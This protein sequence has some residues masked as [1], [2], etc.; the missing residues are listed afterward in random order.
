MDALSHHRQPAHTLTHTLRAAGVWG[1]WILYSHRG[2]VWLSAS[3]LP[4]EERRGERK[5]KGKE[6]IYLK[7]KNLKKKNLND[8]FVHPSRQHLSVAIPLWPLWASKPQSLPHVTS[9][10]MARWVR[11]CIPYTWEYG[12]QSGN[13]LGEAFPF[14]IPQYPSAQ[15]QVQKGTVM[16]GDDE[17]ECCLSDLKAAIDFSRGAGSST[18]GW[19]HL[20]FTPFRCCNRIRQFL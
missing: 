5:K 7:K 14:S 20:P 3:P 16:N 17:L 1:R 2:K 15:S 11:T 10:L 6:K 12:K 8:L 13:S 4:G 18:S 19:N 9:S